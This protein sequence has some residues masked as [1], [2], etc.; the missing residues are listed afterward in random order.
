MKQ[1]CKI[2]PFQNLLKSNQFCE[3]LKNM[4]VFGKFLK[5]LLRRIYDGYKV[6]VV[7]SVVSIS[8]APA[9]VTSFALHFQLD[10]GEQQ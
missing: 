7:V 6:R 2:G 1:I 5:C 10:A 3:F 9:S 4:Y 8:S